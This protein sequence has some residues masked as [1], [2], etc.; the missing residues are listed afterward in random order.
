[1]TSSEF[2]KKLTV[3]KELTKSDVYKFTNLQFDRTGYF[4]LYPSLIGEFI[5]DNIKSALYYEGQ[6]TVVR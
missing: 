3:E 5:R 4:L 6:I 2:N 1:M